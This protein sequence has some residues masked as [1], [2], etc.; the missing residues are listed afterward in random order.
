MGAGT[1][2]R[3][4][5]GQTRC[6]Y[7]AECGSLEV[8]RW[9]REHDCEWD[10]STCTHAASNGHLAM[11]K[12]AVEHGCPWIASVCEL[13]AEQHGYVEVAQWVR[14]Q[15]AAEEEE[16]E[17]WDEDEDEDASEEEEEDEE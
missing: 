9:A 12:R 17:D 1:R 3:M 16:D 13:R 8:L 5:R 15:P 10:S 4:G 6:A 11:L 14:D 2:L 7:A